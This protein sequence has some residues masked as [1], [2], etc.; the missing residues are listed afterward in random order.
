MLGALRNTEA[1]RKRLRTLRRSVRGDM[2]GIIRM[3]EATN[4]DLFDI[5]AIRI[6]GQVGH[7]ATGASGQ[8]LPM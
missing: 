8:M 6:D 5:E 1:A 2:P 3:F 7:V 4:Q